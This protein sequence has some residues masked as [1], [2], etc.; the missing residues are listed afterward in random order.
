MVATMSQEDTQVRLQIDVRKRTRNRLKAEA[1]DLD[2]DMSE[3]GQLALD[4]LL[5]LMADGKTPPAL[6]QAIEKHKKER[7]AAN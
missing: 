1:A 3:L 5:G 4:Y 6:A 2:L 7:D